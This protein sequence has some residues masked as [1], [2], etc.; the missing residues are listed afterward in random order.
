MLTQDIT[1]GEIINS[2]SRPP[3]RA[4]CGYATRGSSTAPARGRPIEPSTRIG[5]HRHGRSHRHPFPY[6]RRQCDTGAA[7]VAG[8]SRRD[9]PAAGDRPFDR[10]AGPPSRPAGSTRRWVSRRWSSRPCRRPRLQTHLELAD[11]PIIDKATLTVLGNDDF[12]LVAAAGRA[13]PAAMSTTMSPGRSVDLARLGVKVINAGGAAAFKENVRALRPRR[14]G[15]GYGVTS[16][17]IVM[18]LQRRGATS[19]AFRI[20]CMSIATISAL[21]ATP[22]RRSRRSRRRGR[23]AASRPCAV[24]CL[25][26]GGQA[27]LL[28]GRAAIAEAVNAHPKRDARCR[29]G[30]VR[31]DLHDLARHAAPVH[32][33]QGGAAAQMDPGRRRRRRRRHRA[34]PLSAATVSSTPCNWRSASSCFC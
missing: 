18:A 17:A 5:L 31:P 13:G 15:A 21:P 2:A 11:I 24:L 32:R 4:I 1:G 22:T 25:W 33:P 8:A 26:H 28:L 34:V 3:A 7:V 16:R 12:L 29:P 20:R 14:R 10:R 9:A 27:R 30:D 23:A 6:W 19:S